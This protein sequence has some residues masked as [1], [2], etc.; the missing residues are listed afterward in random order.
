MFLYKLEVL[1]AD[2]EVVLIVMGDS[3]EEVMNEAEMHLSKYYV[4]PPVIREIVLV[5]KKRANKGS[6]YVIEQK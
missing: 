5:E 2:R 1:L 4:V 6:A 3:D